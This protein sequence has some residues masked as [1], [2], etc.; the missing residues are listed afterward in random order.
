MHEKA[1]H[2]H[3][4]IKLENILIKEDGSLKICDFGFSTP[5]D[6]EISKR[7]GTPMYMAPEIHRASMMS[8][9]A[10]P[11]DV[12]SLGVLFFILAF[13]APPFREAVKNDIYFNFLDMK[14]GNTDFFK[15]H[16]HTKL[17]FKQEKIPTS[18]IDMMMGL[19][20]AK[21]ESRTL[22]LGKLLE[23]EFLKADEDQLY[24]EYNLVK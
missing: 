18:F 7:I 3:M 4:D 9:R 21:P 2:A 23:C 11:T 24:D 10:I 16:P 14:P 20:M 17:L 19:L 6:S 22:E 8:C 13:G 12:F 5:V 1:G 15:Y